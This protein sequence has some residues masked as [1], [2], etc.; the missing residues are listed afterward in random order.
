MDLHFLEDSLYIRCMTPT[1]DMSDILQDL[2]AGR[3]DAAE[4]ARRIDA[5]SVNNVE[6]HPEFV[7]Q[8]EPDD[9]RPGEPTNEELANADSPAA[10]A[11]ATQTDRPQST[12]Y[13]SDPFPGAQA[14]GEDEP[15]D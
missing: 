10:D 11:W 7:A 2:A 3:I 5:L 14:G 13:P 8:T 9:D 12:A 1:P 15:S 4:A 6:P